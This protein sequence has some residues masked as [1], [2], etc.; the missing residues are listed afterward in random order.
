MHKRKLSA[1]IILIFLFG[2]PQ[3]GKAQRLTDSSVNKIEM[4]LSAFGVES[5]GFPNIQA[6]IDLKKDTSICNVSYYDPKF[7]DTSYRLDKKDI[8][9][10]KSLL[11]KYDVK[12]LQRNYTVS[13]TDQPTS[14]TIFYLSDEKIEIK[15]YGLVEELPLKRLYDLVYKLDINYR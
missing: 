5:D 6:T 14:I 7:K 10:I 1:L 9:Y 15:D 11:N 3:I 4:I 13:K 12:R 2:N 8:D